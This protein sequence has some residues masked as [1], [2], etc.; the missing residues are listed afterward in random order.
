MPRNNEHDAN[1]YLTPPGR[2]Y[3]K[4]GFDRN[5]FLPRRTSRIVPSTIIAVIAAAVIGVLLAWRG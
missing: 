1:M 3:Y 4:M 2:T 5:L